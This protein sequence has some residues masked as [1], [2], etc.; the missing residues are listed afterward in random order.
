MNLECFKCGRYFSDLSQ[1]FKHLKKIHL[2]ENNLSE[3]SCLVSKCGKTYRTF[4]SLRS[5]VKKCIVQAKSKDEFEP[6][7]NL[8]VENSKQEDAN[9]E[10]D[11]IEHVR[12]ID[13]HSYEYEYEPSNENVQINAPTDNAYVYEIES[14]SYQMS[15]F[16]NKYSNDIKA[17][18]LTNQNTDKIFDLSIRLIENFTKFCRNLLED[19]RYNKDDVLHLALDYVRKKFAEDHSTYKRQ[20]QLLKNESFINPQT[21]VLGT[22]WEMVKSKS[23]NS[24]IPRLLESKIHYTP[25][26][27]TL[28]SLFKR[29]EFSDMYFEHNLGTNRHRCQEGAYKYFCCGDLFKK[30]ELFLDQPHA[31]QLQI[32]TDDF[33]ICDPLGSK[34]GIHKMTPI[35][36]TIKNVPSHYLSKL[37]NI[38]LVS[39]SRA[40]DV[41]TKETDF[42]D[43][44]EHVVREII[45]LENTGIQIE[46]KPNLRG[47]ISLMGFDN[48]GA[49]QTLGFVESF[50][51]HFCRF[52]VASKKDT[53]AMITED[54]SMLRNI[55]NYEYHLKIVEES[56]KVNFAETKGVKRSC[57]LN[58]LN[59]FHIINNKSVDIMH[60]LNEGC[61][62]FLMKHLFHYCISEKMF[63]E[64]WLE[65]H[66]QYFAFSSYNKSW[67]SHINM[68]KDNLNQNASQLMCLFRNLGFVLYQ[69]RE[70][71]SL[72]K[73]WKCV[74]SLQIIVQICFSSE[75]HVSDINILRESISTHLS[76]ILEVFK[77]PLIPKHHLIT[78]YPGIILHMGPLCHMNM[79]RFESKH[80]SLKSIAKRGN[81]FINITQT[82]SIRSQ[83]ELLYKGFTYC[84]DIDCGKI[85]RI[86]VTQLEVESELANVLE[87]RDTV[88]EIE[89]YK[90]NNLTFKKDL[91]VMHENYFHQIIRIFAVNDKYF[92]FSV[93]FRFSEF[94]S[95]IHCLIIEKITPSIKK[96][97]P[98]NDL[99]FKKPYEIKL[100]G[101]KTAIFAENLDVCRAMNT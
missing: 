32:A 24:W 88:F 28:Q 100:I 45:H 62:P 82:I 58:K 94:D 36:F 86:D 50:N 16:L 78:H 76:S 53:Q 67:P 29:K 27:P 9:I 7:S 18:F 95:F 15:E 81:N 97:I 30:S 17:M 71:K 35:Y 37:S 23:T 91:V 69:F 20:Q 63:T 64:D 26:L 55:E 38:N 34:S 87:E 57:A 72:K 79:M 66:I 6:E 96:L 47:T 49:N 77:L 46:S 21:K 8:D 39:L 68:K 40:D 3:L 85:S 83:A 13:L 51:S 70:D 80:K 14:H 99:N 4:D 90:C 61:I 5:H 22:H 33:E 1:A 75:I 73:V 10:S 43:L 25:I 42:N 59:Y 65:K 12:T 41:K 84:D 98:L 93:K 2:L 60:D 74:E 19:S 54:L 56:E 89:W 52:C 92:L 101:G 11:I 48:L 31:L 44:W